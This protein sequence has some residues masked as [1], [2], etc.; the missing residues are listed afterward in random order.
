MLLDPRIPPVTYRL[1]RRHPYVCRSTVSGSTDAGVTWT[2]ISN[3]L[4]DCDF[5]YERSVQTGIGA[6]KA[7]EIDPSNH[8]RL[9]LG[10]TRV[11]QWTRST[12]LWVP[13]SPYLVDHATPTVQFISALAIAA[14]DS[15]HI[16]AATSEGDLFSTTDGGAWKP[17]ASLELTP[18]SF[19]SRIEV[20]PT[21]ANYVAVAVQNSDGRPRAMVTHDGGGSWTE[22]TR[23]P[24]R[25]PDGI[26][27]GCGL[28]ALISIPCDIWR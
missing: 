14:S 7:F 3:G 4:T 8:N 12:N 27:R 2:W 18:L 9:L 11:Y 5:N 22:P 20:D 6:W 24:A 13:I 28:A 19:I 10:A 23:G 15:N 1:R 25:R 26:H 21:D 16:Y 17:S